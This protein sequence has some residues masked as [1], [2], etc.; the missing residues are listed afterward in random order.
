[1]FY[2]LIKRR[3][4]AKKHVEAPLYEERVSFIKNRLAQGKAQSTVRETAN[5]LLRIVELLNLENRKIP[6]TLSEIECG[7][8]EWAKYQYNHPQKRCSYSQGSK[9]R[10]QLN[11]VDSKKSVCS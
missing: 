1:M 7:A 3:F 4:H 10:R 5:Y 11:W 2:E 6:V 8:E 9:G